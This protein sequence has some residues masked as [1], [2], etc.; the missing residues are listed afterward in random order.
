ME[1]E[2][3]EEEREEEEEEEKEE[4]AKE[5]KKETHLKLSIHSLEVC[6]NRHE[7]LYDN[8]CVLRVYGQSSHATPTR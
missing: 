1:E 5:E 4:E 8:A 7:V 6:Y 2:E 3:E